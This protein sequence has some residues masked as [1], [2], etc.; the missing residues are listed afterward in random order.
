MKTLPVTENRIATYLLFSKDRPENVSELRWNAIIR[1][2]DKI[3]KIDYCK[4]PSAQYEAIEEL[5]HK[6]LYHR[7][8]QF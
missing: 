6:E 8:Q 1:Y 7:T 3:E 5:D 2:F 4:L